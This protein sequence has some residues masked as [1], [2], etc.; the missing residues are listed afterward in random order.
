MTPSATQGLTWP[1][2][3]RIAA[4]IWWLRLWG[5]AEAPEVGGE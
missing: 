4:E 5:V 3:S 1:D 2:E